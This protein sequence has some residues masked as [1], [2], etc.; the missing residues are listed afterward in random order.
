MSDETRHPDASA[1]AAPAA[2]K[3]RRL[4]REEQAKLEIGHTEIAKPLQWLLVIVL[5]GATFAEPVVQV[6][7]DHSLFRQNKRETPMPE[8]TDL[9][10]LMPG[11]WSD[12]VKAYRASGGGWF[13][14]TVA[15][16][17]V[18][19]RHMTRWENDL[20]DHSMVGITVRPPTQEL[21]CRAGVGNEKAY[22][23][24]DGWLYFRPEIDH[25]TQAPFLDAGQLARRANSGTETQAAP[26][27]DPRKAIV[28]FA[29]QLKARGIELIVLPVP[30]KPQV[31]PEK[32]SSRYDGYFGPLYNASFARFVQD[33]RAGGVHVI[34]LAPEMVRARLGGNEQFLRTD[35]HWRPEVMEQAAQALG[36]Y[37][38]GHGLLGEA[39]GSQPSGAGYTRV[40]E[41]ASALG[42]I[43]LMLKLPDDQ[44]LYPKQTV[45]VH[46]VVKGNGDAAEPD[47]SADV[48]L[49]GDSYSNIYSVGAMGWGEGAGLAEQ[50]AFALRRPVDRISRNDSGAFA[51]REMLAQQMRKTD[52]L[53]GKKL[54]IWQFAVRE[55]SGGDW[56]LIDLPRPPQSSSAGQAAAGGE[57]VI[58]GTIADASAPKDPA[59]IYPDYVRSIH[60]TDITVIS[61]SLSAG[62]AVAYVWSLRRGVEQP[63]YRLASGLRV[64]LKL[65]PLSAVKRQVDGI[66]RSEFDDLELIDKLSW[67]AE[68]AP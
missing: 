45:T 13:D 9:V 57:V 47:E 55:L 16:N 23:G 54:V 65:M 22:V 66:N 2:S 6:F 67:L 51:T 68:V 21:M 1:P 33:V 4:T 48:L 41:S 7:W 24:L 15:A 64:R 14:R 37:I 31:H 17:S 38:R 56:R 61:G 50:L 3:P 30:C 11:V 18:L 8:C 63:G 39:A 35:T 52:R 34:D 19:M 5:F 60:V 40:A 28:H 25:L 58:E 62:D 32:F 26:Q 10:R 12:M 29:A 20:K 42:D 53:A 36:E 59:T 46:R 49:L 43:A 27:P 44:T